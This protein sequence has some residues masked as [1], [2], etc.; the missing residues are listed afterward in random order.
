MFFENNPNAHALGN[1]AKFL[2][3]RALVAGNSEVRLGERVESEG[4]LEVFDLP[5][6]CSMA[7]RVLFWRLRKQSCH[8]CRWCAKGG[9]TRGMSRAEEQKSGERLFEFRF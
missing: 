2:K 8:G 4:E 6:C 3:E 5:F 1:K 7:F 9:F